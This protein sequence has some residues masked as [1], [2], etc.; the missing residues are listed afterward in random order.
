[1]NA[2]VLQATAWVV[3][4]LTILITL[5]SLQVSRLRLRHRVTWGDGGHKDL[6]IAIRTHGNT[7]EQSL[8]F[9]AMLI[10]HAFLPGASAAMVAATGGTFVAARLLYWLAVQARRLPLRQVAHLTSVGC[11]LALTVIVARL[12]WPA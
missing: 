1:M 6:V 12:A 2:Q 4:A 3:V 10:C 7:L 8:L 5:L 11:Q 9:V